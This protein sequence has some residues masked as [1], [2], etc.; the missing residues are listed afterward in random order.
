MCLYTLP[1]MWQAINMIAISHNF[2][3]TRA[4]SRVRVRG[5]SGMLYVTYVFTRDLAAAARLSNTHVF[6]QGL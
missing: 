3:E 2:A 1:N 5:C 6:H 4:R